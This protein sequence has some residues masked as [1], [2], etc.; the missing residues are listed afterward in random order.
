VRQVAREDNAV[1]VGGCHV[2]RSFSFCEQLLA[3]SLVKREYSAVRA[4]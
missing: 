2:W 3:F 4:E 1:D